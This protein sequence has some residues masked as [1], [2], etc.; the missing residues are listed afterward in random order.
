VGPW[1]ISNQR[2][3]KWEMT[4]PKKNKKLLNKLDAK[5]NNK[6]RPIMRILKKWNK[7]MKKNRF[8]SFHL[9]SIV[10]EILSNNLTLK[11]KSYSE[12]IVK[13]APRITPYIDKVLTEPAG[14]GPKLII[15]NEQKGLLKSKVSS[16]VKLSK[17]AVV[18][19]KQK[20]VEEAILIWK[21][22]FGNEFGKFIK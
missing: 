17:K 19:E 20:K 8:R 4:D 22:V 2:T 12:I 10:Y 1:Y 14:V 7:K 6:A 5:F 13:I 9:E 16:L 3:N 18:L 21:K 11:T 15:M